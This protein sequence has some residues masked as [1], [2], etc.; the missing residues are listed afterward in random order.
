MTSNH[1][2]DINLIIEEECSICLEP[3]KNHSF[4]IL[5]CNHY[6]HEKCIKK[7]HSKKPFCPICSRDTLL[8]KRIIFTK[9]KIR[10]NRC[11]CI[12]QL[13]NKIILKIKS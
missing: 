7:W 10:N 13:L 9:N 1:N 2:L 6:Y 8:S 11:F 3:L 12:E 4:C 5:N